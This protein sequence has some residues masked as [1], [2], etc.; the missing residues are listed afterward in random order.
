MSTLQKVLLALAFSLT[1]LGFVLVSQKGTSFGSVSN[2]NEY[3]A[4][5]TVNIFDGTSAI[6]GG[7]GGQIISQGQTTLGSVVI[8]GANTGIINFYDGTTT[9]AHSMYATTSVASIPA[10]LAA[11]TYTFDVVVTRGLHCHMVGAAGTAPT[12][13]VTWRK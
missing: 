8:T 6:C 2:Y 4:T 10:S 3:T 1:L 7:N 9:A 5:S 13:T 11:G 12:S